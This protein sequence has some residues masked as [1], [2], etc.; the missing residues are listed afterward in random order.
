MSIKGKQIRDNTVTQEKMYILTET[1][2]DP[3]NVTNKEYVDSFVSTSL[4]QV[5]NSDADMA[6][7]ANTT[8]ENTGAQP[9]CSRTI[10]DIPIS[11]VRVLVNG[12]EMRVG[13]DLAGFDCFFSP[14]LGGI[15]RGAGEE[16]QGDTL[17]WNT[18]FT[19]FQLDPND[20]ID[21][22]YLVIAATIALTGGGAS[23]ASQTNPV[24]GG[25]SDPASQTDADDGGGA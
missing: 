10:T 21:Y 6:I 7:V 25:T 1:I 11:M 20:K 5:G 3:I 8:I 2:I 15:V 23:F 12:V 22:V 24:F 14:D 17:Y 19:E 13:S 16:Q 9:A 4:N 18:D